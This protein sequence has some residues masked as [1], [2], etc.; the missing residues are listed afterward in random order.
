MSNVTEESA[1]ALIDA[2]RAYG[3]AVRG[4]WSTFDGRSFLATTEDMIQVLEG[5]LTLQRFLEDQ[6][7]CVE[8]ESR[9]HW[10]D[11]CDWMHK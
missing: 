6:G 8:G 5:K 7:V 2:L 11:H 10:T 3:Q 9:G 4:D 1:K